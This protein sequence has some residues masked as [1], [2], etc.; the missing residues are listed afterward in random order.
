MIV[1]HIIHYSITVNTCMYTCLAKSLWLVTLRLSTPSVS[2]NMAS[3]VW[4][5][6]WEIWGHM[7]FAAHGLAMVIIVS[8]YWV[9]YND[10][11]LELGRPYF[12]TSPGPNLLQVEVSS[13]EN[14][15]TT[16]MGDFPAT[17]LISRRYPI[18]NN[19]KLWIV[20]IY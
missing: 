11:L 2:L 12:Q 7:G 15:P 16:Q 20:I 13:S 9:K 17:E 1:C 6:L 8:L 19:Q 3:C 4:R 14:H 10:D 18:I 5:S